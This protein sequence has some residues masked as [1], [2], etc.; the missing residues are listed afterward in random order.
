MNSGLGS[1][2]HVNNPLPIAASGA[3]P[4]SGVMEYAEPKKTAEQVGKMAKRQVASMSDKEL[5]ELIKQWDSHMSR[6][7]EESMTRSGWEH[8]DQGVKMF[9]EITAFNEEDDNGF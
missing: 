9:E 4:I 3:F 7:A 6:V 5:G 8:F 2:G 1:V